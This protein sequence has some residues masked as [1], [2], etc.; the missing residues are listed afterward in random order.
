MI[1]KPTGHRI[2]WL[3]SVRMPSHIHRTVDSGK[4]TICGHVPADHDWILAEVPRKK[5]GYSRYCRTC[6]KDGGKSL[7]WLSEISVR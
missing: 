2:G 3:D 5:L 6:F 1:I 4:T 7:P